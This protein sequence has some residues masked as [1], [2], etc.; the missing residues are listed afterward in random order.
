MDLFSGSWGGL[1]II[2]GE[3]GEAHNFWDIGSLVK[4]QKE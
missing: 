1:V 4:K 2:L 3:L